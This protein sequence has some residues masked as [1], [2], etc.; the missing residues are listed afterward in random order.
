MRV[1]SQ[2]S[3]ATCLGVLQVENCNAILEADKK[4]DITSLERKLDKH[5]VLLVKQQIGEQD[6]FL[7]PQ[8]LAEDGKT[9]RQVR[10]NCLSLL[11][12][13]RR[14]VILRLFRLPSKY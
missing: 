1:E 2:V 4:N 6:L 12:W 7:L 3:L 10:Y 8:A 14:V 9:L 5:L 13:G 11:K